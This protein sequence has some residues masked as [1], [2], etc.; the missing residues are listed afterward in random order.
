[1]SMLAISTP[2]N[3]KIFHIIHIDRFESVLSDGY[4]F[5]DAKMSQKTN[6][7]SIIGISKIKQR[8]LEKH[9]SSYPDLT[10]GQCV[11][12]YF[13]PRSVMLHSIYCKNPE[14]SYSEGQDNII[15]LVFDLNN[16]LNWATNNNLRTCYTSSN[17]G[18]SYFEDYSDFSKIDLIIDWNS[19]NAKYWADKEIKE[20]KQSEFLIENKI[21][22]NLLVGIGVYNSQNYE[23]VKNML[24]NHNIFPVVEIRKDWYY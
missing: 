13:C 17:A 19:V 2:T 20:K 15:H 21:D 10:V 3:I 23:K 1:M 5:C 16:V 11:P 4:L 9:L 7:G 24:N 12:F 22:I 8:R 6:I 14:L 18:S